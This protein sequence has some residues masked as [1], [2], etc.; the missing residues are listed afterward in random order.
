MTADILDALTRYLGQQEQLAMLIQH[1]LYPDALP[2]KCRLPAVRMVEVDVVNERVSLTGY[3]GLRRARIQFDIFAA[4]R[5]ITLA[6]ADVLSA[7][8]N[9]KCIEGVGCKLWVL[10]EKQ[11]GQIDGVTEIRRRILEFSILCQEDLV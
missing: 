4:Q 5:S 9:G 10:S 7:L 1:R 6:V 8:M 3:S 11:A 2:T